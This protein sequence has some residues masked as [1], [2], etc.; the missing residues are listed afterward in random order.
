M[1]NNF[2]PLAH[3]DKL[4]GCVGTKYGTVVLKKE[5][6]RRMDGRWVVDASVTEPQ[7]WLEE[8]G[9][10]EQIAK[11]SNATASITIKCID[12]EWWMQISLVHS[13]K[14]GG[15]AKLG[16]F[17]AEFLDLL[18]AEYSTNPGRGKKKKS[19]ILMASFLDPTSVLSRE[20]RQRIEDTLARRRITL[21]KSSS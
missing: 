19:P 17:G 5:T 11:R 9:Y 6:T 4:S 8:L 2:T 10:L 12:G 1:G 3:S 7:A 13:A 16:R 21:G 18:A 20:R 15:S 14:S